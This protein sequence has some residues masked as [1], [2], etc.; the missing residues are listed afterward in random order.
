[1]KKILGVKRP[2]KLGVKQPVI[3]VSMEEEIHKLH[4]KCTAPSHQ[5]GLKSCCHTAFWPTV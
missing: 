1:M 2:L 3:V 5:V 4:R